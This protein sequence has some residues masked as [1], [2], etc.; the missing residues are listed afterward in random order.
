MSK[1]ES[2]LIIMTLLTLGTILLSIWYEE[3]GY[4]IYAIWILS[5]VGINTN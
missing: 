5:F 1:F 3:L 2:N 4:L